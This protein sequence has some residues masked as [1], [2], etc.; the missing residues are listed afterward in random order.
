MPTA[1][2]PEEKNQTHILNSKVSFRCWS[3]SHGKLTNSVLSRI[4]PIASYSDKVKKIM[5]QQRF[6]CLYFSKCL[7][8]YFVWEL[9]SHLTYCIADGQ[10]TQG[11]QEA[12]STS[13]DCA[14]GLAFLI[15]SP[16]AGHGAWNQHHV[17][18]S[19]SSLLVSVDC[20]NCTRAGGHSKWYFFVNSMPRQLH[21]LSSC[22]EALLGSEEWHSSWHF[23]L[24]GITGEMCWVDIMSL[25]LKHFLIPSGLW[26][27]SCGLGKV[28]PRWVFPLCLLYAIVAP[29][30][31][32]VLGLILFQFL[33]LNF[34]GSMRRT[35]E[36]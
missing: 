17:S 32:E 27:W 35:H 7:C 2:F 15:T 18:L 33:Q 22:T 36:S 9:S 26:P 11:L 29:S 4:W 25:K 8:D 24:S 5:L 21:F 34:I 16:A 30:R 19:S 1:G 3:R 10:C 28:R 14:S 23:T 13:S 31:Q 12:W 20:D 6:F